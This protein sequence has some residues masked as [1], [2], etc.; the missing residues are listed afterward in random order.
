MNPCLR[1]DDRKTNFNFHNKDSMN[2][3]TKRITKKNTKKSTKKDNTLFTLQGVKKILLGIAVVGI[4]MVIWYYGCMWF[5]HGFDLHFLQIDYC[6]DMW[7][8]WDY[9]EKLCK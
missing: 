3:S 4:G 8:V 5:S 7:G 9:P 6:L 2:T 1:G